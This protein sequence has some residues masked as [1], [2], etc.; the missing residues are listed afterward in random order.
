M[1]LVLSLASGEEP[2][3]LCVYLLLVQGLVGNIT[4]FAFVR[5]CL[6]HGV[7]VVLLYFASPVFCIAG[8]HLPSC[9]S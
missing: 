3:V 8:L 9:G 6:A 1:I 4:A 7:Y 5:I 2:S